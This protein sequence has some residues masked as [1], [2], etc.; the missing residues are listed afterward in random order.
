MKE[1]IEKNWIEI[2]LIIITLIMLSFAIWQLI[3]QQNKP[4][5]ERTNL[6]N[7]YIINKGV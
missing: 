7:Y 4:I 2:V 6:A 1:F 5:L 3:L